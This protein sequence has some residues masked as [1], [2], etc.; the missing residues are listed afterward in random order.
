MNEQNFVSVK[1]DNLYQR[2]ANYNLAGLNTQF[3]ENSG[4]KNNI[5]YSNNDILKKYDIIP[6]K[7]LTSNT[8][9]K[10]YKLVLSFDNSDVSS[11]IIL[12]QSFKDVVSVKLLNAIFIKQGPGDNSDTDSLNIPIFITLS[13][14]EL[15]NIYST[16][17][18]DGGSLLNS[19][20]TLEY[21]KT[22]DRDIT[23]NT[24]KVNIYKNKFGI[25]QDIKYFDPPLNS[26]SKFNISLFDDNSN[27]STGATY[28]CKLEFIIETKDKQRV[29]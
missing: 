29:Y 13:I 1:D 9:N 5:S 8:I 18:P 14:N 10:P 27:N 26:L 25:N 22:F 6:H 4:I 28:K 19:F 2:G 20:A 24:H 11:P 17:Q 23:G 3:R 7:G 12:N 16:S 21:D 15:N